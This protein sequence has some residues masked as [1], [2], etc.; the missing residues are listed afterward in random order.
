LLFVFLNYDDQ[1]DAMG[2][3]CRTYGKEN[4]C[5]WVLF[6]GGGGLERRLLEIGLDLGAILKFFLKKWGWRV[7]IR[8]I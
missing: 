3:V 1:E 6:G 5:V 2:V 8:L 7:W 4:K